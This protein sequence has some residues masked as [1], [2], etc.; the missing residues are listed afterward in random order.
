MKLFKTKSEKEIKKLKPILKKIEKFGK[1]IVLLSDEELKQKTNEF[2]KR[3]ENGEKLDKILPEAFAV[4]RE[5]DRRVL[6]MFPYDEQVMCGIL[7]HQGR[8]GELATGQGKTLVSTMPAYLNALTGKGVHVVTVNDYLAARDAEQMGK[9]HEFLGLTV[10]VVLNNSSPLE[11][12]IAYGSDITYITNNELG[13]DYLRDNMATEAADRVQRGLHYVIMDE[14]DSVLIDEARTPLIISGGSGKSTEL[15][16]HADMFVKSLVCG[17]AKEFSK[18]DSLMGEKYEET[19]D[20]IKDE[21]DQV[22]TLTE[23]GIKKAEKVFAIENLS[24]STNIEL[25]HCINTALRANYLM[26]K[27]EHYIVRDGEV[28]IVD[29][30]TGRVMDGRR[31]S[32]GLHQAIEAKEGVEIKE[33]NQTLATVTFQNFFNKYEKKAGMTGTAI[34]E[35]K[36]FQDIYGMDVVAVPTHQPVIRKDLTDVVFLTKKEKY[37][38]I[39]NEVEKAY[40]K[41]QP[42]LVGTASIDVSELLDRALSKRGIPHTVLNAKNDSKEAEIVAKAGIAG[43]VTIATNMAGRGT[44][45]KLDDEA[46]ANGGLKI[47]GTER[48]ESRRIDNQLRGRSG[49]QGDPGESRFY[50]S[51][52]DNLVKRFGSADYFSIYEKN[53]TMGEEITNKILLAAITDAQRRIEDNNYGIRKNLLEYDIVNNHQREI[54][55]AERNK[56][57]DKGNMYATITGMVKDHLDGIVSK[58]MNGKKLTKEEFDSLNNQLYAIYPNLCVRNEE[59]IGA[60]KEIVLNAVVERA[61][62]VYAEKEALFVDPEQMRQLERQVLLRIIDTNWKIH[63]DDMEQLKQWIGIKAYGQKDPKLEYKRLGYQ[64]F[65]EMMMN[66]I[67]QTVKTMYNIQVFVPAPEPK[68]EEKEPIIEEVKTSNKHMKISVAKMQLD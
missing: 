42:V 54:I 5:A 9:V 46:K 23:N 10:G 33:E 55:Y 22:I 63:L 20:Y 37:E 43:A 48:H 56:V 12:Q 32:D 2:K 16:K 1:K 61:M 68:Q 29:E 11:R 65:N 62:S 31:F 24:D 44:D 38:A 27:D 40:K 64:L 6:G 26:H 52:E 18:I 4:V 21:K 35:E 13:F 34:T 8:I 17:K 7:L 41:R 39:C 30:F 57:L 66:I 67:A 47:I 53:H 15:Y 14:V 36:E 60:N 19:G 51:L 45:I 25:Q 3:I 49:R 28:M 59:L 58:S 50:L